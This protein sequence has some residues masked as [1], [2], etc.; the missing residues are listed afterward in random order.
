MF[1]ETIL[2]A[3]RAIRVNG[4]RSALTA[5]GIIIGVAAV[6]ALVT[7]G[8]GA[9]QSVVSG[10]SSLGSQLLTVRPGAPGGASC[11]PSRTPSRASSRSSSRP[12]G[13]ASRPR[14]ASG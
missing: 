1:F 4:L 6:I 7:I 8:D 11:R 2:L 14:C 5:L 13:R 10:I 12:T 3:F 9:Q